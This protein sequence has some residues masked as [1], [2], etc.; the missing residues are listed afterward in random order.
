MS[1]RSNVHSI[2]FQPPP[3]KLFSLCKMLIRNCLS[4]FSL[5]LSFWNQVLGTTV[6][7]CIKQD[8]IRL[9]PSLEFFNVVSLLLRPHRHW[10]QLHIGADIIGVD[11]GWILAIQRDFFLS[12]S[13]SLSLSC[14]FQF[15][16]Y[17]KLLHEFHEFAID[18]RVDIY[19][20]EIKTS[21]GRRTVAPCEEVGTEGV[22]RSLRRNQF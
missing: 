6:Y 12:L 19:C 9:R 3:V 17:F 10:D 18:F 16:E 13:L 7:D 15:F 21:A 11:I 14:Q 4:H 1:I 5:S 20:C 8:D 22:N 2:V